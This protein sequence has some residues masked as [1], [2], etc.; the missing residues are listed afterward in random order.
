MSVHITTER[1]WNDNSSIERWPE[2]ISKLPEKIESTSKYDIAKNYLSYP[3]DHKGRVLRSDEFYGLFGA[4][5]KNKKIIISGVNF[6]KKDKVGYFLSDEALLLKELYDKDAGW[7]KFLAKQLCKYSIRLRAIVTGILNSK[8]MYFP[9]KI[10]EKNAEAYCVVDGKRYYFLND[11]TSKKNINDFMDRY[12]RLSIGPFWLKEL[13]IVEEPFNI[14][15]TTAYNPSVS[16][17]GTYLKMPLSLLKF[18]GWFI[19]K[20]RGFH[21][22]SKEKVKEDI[23]EEVFNSLLLDVNKKDTD[24]LKELICEYSDTRGYFPVQIVGEE[25]KEIIAPQTQEADYRWIDRYFMEGIKMGKFKL[26]GTEQGQP[27]HGR[28]LSGDK[29]KQLIKLDF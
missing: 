6:I 19:E 12:P 18:L 24:L 22:L 3:T 29:E 26:V 16:S 15:G 9:K 8:G 14:Y 13:E 1:F 5:E 17:V 28:G 11:D 25:L 27:R 23:G 4:E 10:L 20:N 7:E 2:I 21:E